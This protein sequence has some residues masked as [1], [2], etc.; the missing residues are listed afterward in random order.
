MRRRERV[1]KMI[2][3]WL[4]QKSR[5]K[6]FSADTLTTIFNTRDIEPHD[7]DKHEGKAL[8]ETGYVSGCF[9]CELLQRTQDQEEG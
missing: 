3:K 8:S 2:N 5:F 9:R 6:N 4:K 1:G 7:V